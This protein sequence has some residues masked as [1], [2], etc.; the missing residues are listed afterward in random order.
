ML[1]LQA[2][3]KLKRNKFRKMAFLPATFAGKHATDLSV[4][5]VCLPLHIFHNDVVDFTKR[6]TIC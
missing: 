2:K 3:D 5:T 4:E 6:S 1:S